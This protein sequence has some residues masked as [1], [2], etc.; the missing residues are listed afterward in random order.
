MSTLLALYAVDTIFDIGANAG[1]SGEYFRELG[2]EGPIVS[3]EPVSRL[4]RQLER[5]A[6]QDPRW[7]CE[8][9]A[10]GDVEGE[11]TINVSDTNGGASSFLAMTD[12]IRRHA[13]E[14]QFIGQERVRVTTIDSVIDRYYPRGDRLFLKLDVQGYEKRVLEGARGSL[15]RV[16]GMKIEMSIVKNYEDELLLC[17]MLP[18]LYDLGFRLTS[19]ENGWANVATQELYQIDG[20]LFRPERL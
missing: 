2:F 14:L 17:D 6:T 18:Y 9:A 13:P 10:L 20:I 12:N 15:A 1:V 5:R 7:S 8:H 16:V 4:Y 3:F 11:L 19:I